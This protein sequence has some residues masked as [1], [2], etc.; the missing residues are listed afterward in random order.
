MSQSCLDCTQRSDGVFCDLEPDALQ[1]FD[2]I[3]SLET[4]PRG[5]VLFREGGTARS[6][7]LLCS[8][9]VRLTVCSESGRRMTLRH[10]AAGELLGLSAALAGGQY[11]VTAEVTETVQVAQI[12]RRELLQFLREHG[13]IC[14]QIVHLLSEDLHVA[15]NRVRSVGLVRTRHHNE[16]H[17]H[18]IPAH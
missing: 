11:E 17:G 9:R 3:K 16:N 2:G 10:A 8:G 6:I 13:D 18:Q 1:Q 14:M 15:Y 12:R 5:T 4:W 7:F